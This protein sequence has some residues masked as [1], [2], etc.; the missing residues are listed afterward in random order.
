MKKSKLDILFI[1]IIFFSQAVYAGCGGC[2]ADRSKTV[3]IKSD[4]E[5]VS[6]IGGNGM[7][8]GNVLASCGMCHFDVKTKDC[9]L[10]IRIDDTP[11]AVKGSSI[12]DH[13]DSHAEDGFCNKVRT[14][15]VKGKVKGDFFFAAS[16]ELNN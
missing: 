15:S 12:D 9:S 4:V 10:Y 6:N 1:S 8:E 14:A 2:K 7:I 3:Q 11:Y 13:G 5:L 16:F